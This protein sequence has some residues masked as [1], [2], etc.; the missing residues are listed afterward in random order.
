MTEVRFYHLLQ[1]SQDQVLPVILSKALERGHKV[2]VKLRNKKEVEHFNEHLWSFSPASFIPHGSANDGNEGMQPIWITAQDENP[3]GADVLIL[4]Q[5]TDADKI[6]GYALCCE[7]LDGHDVDDVQ[8][9][10]RRWKAYK[11]QGYD[12]SYWQ[13]NDRGGWDKKA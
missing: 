9:A 3:N 6:D 7:M 10:R 5:G 13:Q 1:K 2:V 8:A 4:G 12:I 11:E